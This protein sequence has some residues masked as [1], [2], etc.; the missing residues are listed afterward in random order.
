MSE[1]FQII[2]PG[3]GSVY[4]ERAYV[5]RDDALAAV[6]RAAKAQRAWRATSLDERQRILSDAVD[7]IVA[8]RDDLAEELARSMGRPVSQGGGEVGGFEERARYMIDAASSALADLVPEAKPGFR[9]FIRREPVGVVFTIAPW[10]FPYMTAVNSVWP[11]LVAGNAVILKHAQQ[12]VLAGERMA[13]V[14]AEAG[15]PEDVFQ[16]VHMDHDTAGAVMQ[17]EPVRMICF[18]GSVRGGRA[19]QHAV[20]GAS[21][22][23]GTGLELGGKDP[24]YVRADADLDHAA[25]GIADGGFF[26]AGQSC[27]SIERVYVHESVYDD[28]LD[29]LVA[30]ATGL[31]LGDPLDPATTL[32]PLVKADAAEFVRGQVRDAVAAGARALIDPSAFPADGGGYLAP[33]IVVD[34]DH[35]MR[36]MT[37]E[38]FGPVVGVMKVRSDDE[39]VELMND[40]E[41][42]LTA[43]IWTADTEAAEALGDRIETGT[44]YMNRCDYLDP[45]L[46]WTG[47][48]HTGRG[49]TLSVVGYEH[50]T[51]PK[52]FHLRTRT[53]EE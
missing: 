1:T 36:L 41:Y 31:R 5:S 39:A 34:V 19:V 6:E 17:S 49:C 20:S 40:S 16:A 24:A 10:N 46:A 30:E 51:R 2:S 4:A 29:R 42:G 45:A 15:L 32:G 18:T 21:G 48:K 3:D 52:S 7:R 35:S 44:L 23:P 9:R 28:F 33:Q 12:T 14:L 27:C 47:V 26:N 43:A 25:A 8:E 53:R 38:S 11:A 22:F 50:L 37:E 13:R